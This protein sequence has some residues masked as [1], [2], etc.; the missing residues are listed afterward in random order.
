MEFTPKGSN[1]QSRQDM[2]YWINSYISWAF[3]II[4]NIWGNQPRQESGFFWHWGFGLVS[5]LLSSENSS[6][7]KKKLDYWHS[8]SSPASLLTVLLNC[9]RSLTI[10]GCLLCNHSC[11]VLVAKIC[12]EAFIK[13][14]LCRA[15]VDREGT[16]KWISVSEH[17][18]RHRSTAQKWAG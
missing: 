4:A 17:F 13:F 7:L 6:Q 5:F 11:Y 2:E 3:N 8:Q 15:E 12:K 18:T 14:A 1:L 16:Q 10:A 9:T